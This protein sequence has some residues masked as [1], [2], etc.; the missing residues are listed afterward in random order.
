MTLVFASSLPV[1]SLGDSEV[2]HELYYIF[3]KLS[4]LVIQ[5]IGKQISAKHIFMKYFM[6]NRKNKSL[7]D[8]K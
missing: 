1:K 7:K 5:M 4:S 8:Q 6:I 3:I 2:H